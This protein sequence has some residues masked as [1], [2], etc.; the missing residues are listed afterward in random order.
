MNHL[1]HAG[2]L[3][4]V[5]LAVTSARA[6]E[7]PAVKQEMDRLRGTFVMVTGLADGQAMPAPMTNSMKRIAEGNVTT[8]TMAGQLYMKANFSINAGATPRTIDY[9]MTG[10]FTAGKK[11]LGIYRTRGDT[12][13]FC[14][15]YPG[16][17]R[18]TTFESKAGTNVTCSTWKRVNP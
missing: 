3:A 10:G 12:V 1:H 9:D 11:Q 4:F 5:A 7:S 13:D 17:A 14:F 15:G 18:P 6:Q 16:D 2:R 8:V